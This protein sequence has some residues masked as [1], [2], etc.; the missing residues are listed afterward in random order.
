M[1]LRKDWTARPTLEAS[2][3]F[4]SL[5]EAKELK[6]RWSGEFNNSND[7]ILELGCGKGQFS[8]GIAQRYNEKNIIAIDLKDEV[9]YKALLKHQEAEIENIRLVAMN[10]M[11]INEIL[12]KDEIS[13][14]YINFCNP[15]P[16]DRHKKR[17]L[18]HNTFLERYKLFLK[19][20][21]EIWFKTDDDEL[22]EESQEYFKQSG[23][24]IKFMTYDLHNS[25]YNEQNI[26]TE[27]EEK[28][29]EMNIKTKFLIAKWN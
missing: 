14:I 25:E 21:S 1:R 20:G 4:K 9:L 22:F 12:D 23:F 11:M 24:E 27:Y 10:I 8:R 16:K 7:I 15:W 2:G 26:K 28:F 13:R 17:R 18:T 19:M 5:D 3:M 6:G 29:M